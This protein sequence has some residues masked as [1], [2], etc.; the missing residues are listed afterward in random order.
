VIKCYLKIDYKYIL[1][2]LEQVFYK[3]N[4]K[5]FSNLNNRKNKTGYQ[6]NSK[7]NRTEK[8]TRNQLDSPKIMGLRKSFKNY[9]KL[10]QGDL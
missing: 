4:M 8:E 10:D 7:E 3:R 5:R 6:I 1:L 9:T 2:A